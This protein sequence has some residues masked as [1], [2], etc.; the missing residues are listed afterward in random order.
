MQPPVNFVSSLADFSSLKTEAM[1][2]SKTSV[3]TRCT[4]RQ[5]P[6]DGIFHSH[7]RKN[8][9]TYIVKLVAFAASQDILG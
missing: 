8:L 7:R 2:S 5:I 4:R 9:K 6:E 3:Y 1:R